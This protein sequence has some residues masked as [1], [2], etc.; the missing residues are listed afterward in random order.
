MKHLSLLAV[1]ALVILSV[2]GCATKTY[3]RQGI[4]TSYEKDSM[5]CREIELETAKVR[6][7]IDHVNKE[8][9]FSGRDVLAIIGDF[10]IGNGMEKSA[11]LES[12]NKRVEQLGEQRN[13]KK[14][15]AGSA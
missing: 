7:F 6:G 1:S 8:S 2:Q 15:G 11:A 5:T 12:A 4:L 3:G 9:E 10:G 14:C 13:T